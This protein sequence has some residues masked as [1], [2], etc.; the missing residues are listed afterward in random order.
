MRTNAQTHSS[1][2]IFHIFHMFWTMS[3]HENTSNTILSQTLWQENFVVILTS[4][5]HLRNQVTNVRA[6]KGTRHKKYI[7]R[8]PL[9]VLQ[10]FELFFIGLICGVSV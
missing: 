10:S 4:F 8:L 9:L 6:V 5:I 7:D 2:E 1:R 3:A